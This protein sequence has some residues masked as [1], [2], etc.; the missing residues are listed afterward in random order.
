MALK[1]KKDRDW[2]L[3]RKSFVYVFLQFLPLYQHCFQLNRPGFQYNVSK[4]KL[5]DQY[6][7][8]HIYCIA[9]WFGGTPWDFHVVIKICRVELDCVQYFW[10]DFGFF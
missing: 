1:T 3:L 7:L 9:F 6:I 5:E 4:L 2:E 8:L 10:Q